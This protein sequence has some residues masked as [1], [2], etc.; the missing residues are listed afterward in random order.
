MHV[1]I[2]V[3]DTVICKT[4]YAPV[5]CL[6][7][8]KAKCKYFE[9]IIIIIV[10]TEIFRVCVCEYVANIVFKVFFRFVISEDR[11]QQL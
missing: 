2:N 4:P 11:T 6:I 10:I 9:G 8:C 7:F 5:H 1:L 3:F